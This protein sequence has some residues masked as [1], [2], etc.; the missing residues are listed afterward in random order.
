M[1]E[2]TFGVWFR[3]Y[4]RAAVVVVTIGLAAAPQHCASYSIDRSFVSNAALV[5]ALASILRSNS[6]V[7]MLLQWFFWN[8]SVVM[9]DDLSVSD[10]FHRQS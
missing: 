4:L 3:R 1:P 7:R 9:K 5:G 8:D 10:R 6:T 2:K